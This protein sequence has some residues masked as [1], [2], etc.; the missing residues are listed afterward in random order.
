MKKIAYFTL[1]LA[2]VSSICEASEQDFQGPLTTDSVSGF[3]QANHIQNV[4]DL[5]S[6]MPTRLLENFT[7]AFQSGSLQ[8]P[9]ADK[10]TPRVI[11]YS[12]DDE[13]TMAVTGNTSTPGCGDVEMLELNKDTR[14]V[15]LRAVDLT[16]PFSR[17]KDQS[18]ASCHGASAHPI[19]NN[20]PDW[21]GMFGHDDDQLAGDEKEEFLRLK[22]FWIDQPVYRR[23]DW[24]GPSPLAPYADLGSYESITVRPN[25]R[26]GSLLS[27]MNGVRLSQLDQ[28]TPGFS[29]YIYLIEAML[30]RCEIFNSDFVASDPNLDRFFHDFD[31]DI[32]IGDA[33]PGNIFKPDRFT[34][35]SE[36][37]FSDTSLRRE[38]NDGGLETSNLL[39]SQLM[40][41]IAE[42]DPS[43]RP[44]TGTTSAF[45]GYTHLNP[46]PETL[47]E[48][49]RDELYPS[50]LIATLQWLDRDGE[51][52]AVQRSYGST[53]REPL[54][55]QLKSK[56]LSTRSS[57]RAAIPF[58]LPAKTSN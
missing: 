13:F 54:C 37:D 19:W 42:M 14:K 10:S 31:G 48:Q 38:F 33:L 32:S 16:D 17:T 58:E 9:C 6:R 22:S 53:A 49:L 40:N 18:C 47:D 5:L 7:L 2:L 15:A 26:L 8:G 27:R 1:T 21:P 4:D 50:A 46:D 23:L 55:A 52:L 20:Y 3:I 45:V 28:E 34:L 57:E 39:A 56:F 41:R 11:L 25:F 44:Y 35:T 12:P 43:F 30:I 29:D 51:F 24:H 36:L